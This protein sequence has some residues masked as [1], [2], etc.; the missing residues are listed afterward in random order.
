MKIRNLAYAPMVLLISLVLG[1]GGGGGGS[2]GG[3]TADTTPP[4]VSIS[5]PA[6][7]SSV[8][9]T[10]AITANASDNV[11]VTKV[12]FYVNGGLQVTTTTAPY[13]FSWNTSSLSNGTYSLTAKAYD[14]ANNS[15]TSS[16]VSVA[17]NGSKTGPANV[18]LTL[19][20]PSLPASTTVGGVIFTINL[21]PGV[22]PAVLS[23]TDASGS[24]S[25][26][27]GAVG[28]L[29]FADFSSSQI[30]FG[31]V[32]LNSFGTGNFMIVNCVIASGATV[33]PSG[34]SILTPQVFDSVGT[35]IPSATIDMS[36]LLS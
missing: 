7:N 3:T 29:S 25:L 6:N 28:S 8:S 9:G 11:G 16:A 2:G 20:I 14:A 32:T 36:V 4:S 13:T 17:V 18:T 15:T 33:S 35:L 10:I 22:S 5:V 12:E 34:F 1:C 21:P 24:V 30:T 31:S 19:S 23:G 26:T 27:G